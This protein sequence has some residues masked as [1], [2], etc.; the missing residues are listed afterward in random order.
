MFSVLGKGGG[1]GVKTNPADA[2][3]I[4]G[5]PLIHSVLAFCSALSEDDIMTMAGGACPPV[6]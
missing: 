3:V 1:G 4:N 2:D 6:S 5:S